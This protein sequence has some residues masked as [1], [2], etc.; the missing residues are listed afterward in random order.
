MFGDS[1]Q[2]CFRALQSH[3]TH[4][5]SFSGDAEIELAFTSGEAEFAAMNVR[6]L[7]NRELQATLV[8]L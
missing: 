6:T 2:N 8:I 4:V 7:R 1:S 5:T 3:R